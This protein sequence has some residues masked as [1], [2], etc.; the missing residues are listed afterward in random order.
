MTAL[1]YSIQRLRVLSK[2]VLTATEPSIHFLD[3]VYC[4]L[5]VNRYLP[6]IFK[7]IATYNAKDKLDISSLD[8]LSIE[9][10]ARYPN[11]MPSQHLQQ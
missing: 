10:F 2:A 1:V 11:Q 3:H 9:P 7:P 4:L 6:I 8:K 5:R